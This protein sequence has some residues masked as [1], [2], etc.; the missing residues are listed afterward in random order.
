MGNQ[1]FN[2]AC[3]YAAARREGDTLMLDT[4]ECDNS[5]LRKFELDN[6]HLKY[7]A[8]ESFPNRNA[9]QKLY[10]KLR[11]NLKYRVI[12]EREVYH[13]RGNRY[14]VNDI[15]PR[16]FEKKRFRNKYLQGYW[17]HLPYFE[18]YLDEI[19][20]MMTPAYEQSERVQILAKEFETTPTCAVHVRGGDIGGP[21]GSYFK[22]A[23][24]RMEQEKPG[25]RYIVF[26]NDMEKARESLSAAFAADGGAVKN[27]GRKEADRRMDFVTELGSFSD[28]DEFFLMAACQNQILSNSTYS[29]WAAYLNPNREKTVIMPED[30]LSER[31]RLKDWIVLT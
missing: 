13:N 29:T 17:Q 22:N 2:Y 7:D 21:G 15:D 24:A 5:T 23:I 14:T 19:R 31:M 18:E 25:V 30:I 16:V 28:V 3:G 20:E 10:K 27:G 9:W 1:L 12:A 6:F 26:T 11:R 8:R 4:S